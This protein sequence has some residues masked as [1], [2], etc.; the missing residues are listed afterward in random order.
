MPD[1]IKDKPGAEAFAPYHGQITGPA[2][3]TN[4][5]LGEIGASQKPGDREYGEQED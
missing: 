1:H 4:E 2:R 3:P 5:V